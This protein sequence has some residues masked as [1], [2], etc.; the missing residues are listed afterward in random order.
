MKWEDALGIQGWMRECE[1]KWLYDQ[2]LEMNSV[3]EIGS[4]KGRS[5]YALCCGCRGE[6]Y[7]VDHFLG[8]REHA[9]LLASGSHV[10]L[11][12]PFGE[13][14]SNME[15]FENISLFRGSSKEASK[16]ELIPDVVDMVFIDGDHTY[17]GV[18]DD[19]RLWA[20]RAG[21][22]LCGH[23]FNEVQVR[24]ALV[25]F[26]HQETIYSVPETWLWWV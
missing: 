7:A 6:V 21:K 4:W 16:S 2:S 26:F 1:L 23:D 14:V 20:H 9:M 13:F 12:N 24:E 11:D 10:C 18:M 25:D 17:E 15:G 3:L 8:S 22:L 5:T 19:L